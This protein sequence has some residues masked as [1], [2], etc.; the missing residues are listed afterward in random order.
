MF[1]S[2]VLGRCVANV[3]AAIVVGTV[4]WAIY[5]GVFSLYWPLMVD[6]PSM[7]CVTFLMDHGMKPYR[8]ITNNNM[9]GSY[10]TEAW[11]MQP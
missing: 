1:S 9:L 11:A 8:E 4:A 10:L 7:H 3:R 2:A 5:C 6:S